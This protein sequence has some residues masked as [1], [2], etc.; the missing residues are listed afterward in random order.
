MKKFPQWKTGFTRNHW[1]QFHWVSRRKRGILDIHACDLFFTVF[2]PWNEFHL[3][4]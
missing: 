4:N 3:I 2:S 1:I